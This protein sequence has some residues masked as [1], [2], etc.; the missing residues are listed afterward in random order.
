MS[1]EGMVQ[2]GDV[3]MGVPLAI[4]NQAEA[5]VQEDQQTPQFADNEGQSAYTTEA[6]EVH[7]SLGTEA[8]PNHWPPEL[9]EEWERREKER[10]DAFSQKAQGIARQKKELEEFQRKAQAY[11]LMM[12]DPAQARARI[13]GL[14]G[15]APDPAQQQAQEPAVNPR[16]V[17]KDEVVDAVDALIHQRLSDFKTT[18][19]GALQQYQTAIDSLLRQNVE[20]DWANLV[21]RYPHASEFKDKVGTFCGT[22]GITDLEQAYFAVAGPDAVKAGSQSLL[23]KEATERRRAQSIQP[24]ST[25]HGSSPRP[26]SPDN[27]KMG[28]A[29]VIIQ[30]AREHGVTPP[31]PW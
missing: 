27:K 8:A 4:D 24:T 21:K 20:R 15:N 9:Q 7:D 14:L 17:L 16:E 11:D 28:L 26:V 29:D 6:Q 1:E 13:Q 22:T 23:K 19:L 30:V 10:N 12:S 18:D 25:T 5:Q 3:G 2:P 31:Q